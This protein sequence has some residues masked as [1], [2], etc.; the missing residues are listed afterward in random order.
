M[1]GAKL[2]LKPIA[3]LETDLL[4]IGAANNNGVISMN[5]SLVIGFVTT[6]IW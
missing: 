4:D 1:L 5:R 2:N 6:T 3:S